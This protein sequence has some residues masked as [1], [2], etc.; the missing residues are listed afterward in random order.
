VE[1]GKEDYEEIEYMPP[2]PIGKEG[3]LLPVVHHSDYVSLELFLLEPPYTPP[4]DFELPDYKQLGRTLL[5]L[6]HPYPVADSPPQF[7][8]VHEVPFATDCPLLLPD[9]GQCRFPSKSD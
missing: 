4:F 1:E 9:L 8:Y 2:R 6:T 5:E 3:L 7:D